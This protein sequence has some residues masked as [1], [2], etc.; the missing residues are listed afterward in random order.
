MND[1]WQRVG[2]HNI[3]TMA[4]EHHIS[5]WITKNTALP[6][7]FWVPST[8]I[9]PE[10]LEQCFWTPCDLYEGWSLYREERKTMRTEFSCKNHIL[11][12]TFSPVQNTAKELSNDFAILHRYTKQGSI[13]DVIHNVGKQYIIPPPE[14]KQW[15]SFSFLFFLV[16]T[17][18]LWQARGQ[19]D[20][21]AGAKCKFRWRDKRE[22]TD[23]KREGNLTLF[24]TCLRLTL[25]LYSITYPEWS[26]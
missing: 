3:S 1:P 7:F 22:I 13:T 19:P 20:R 24:Q 16:L 10:Q 23:K 9:H 21:A 4:H 15:T 12:P 17:F 26:I 25:A 8:P 14:R 11:D 2:V 18:R 5:I 6:Y